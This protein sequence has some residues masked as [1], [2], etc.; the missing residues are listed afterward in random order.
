MGVLRR[1]LLTTLDKSLSPVSTDRLQHFEARLVTGRFNRAHQAVVDQ[2]GDSVQDVKR[3][4]GAHATDLLGRIKGETADEDRQSPEQSPLLRDQEVVAPGDRVAHRP[5]ASGQV[6]P[7]VG[8][9][10]EAC[11]Q[12]GQEG[13]RGE[14]FGASG[15][16]LDSER[17]AVQATTDGGHGGGIVGREGEPGIDGAG[18]EG[19]KTNRIGSG[20][21]VATPAAAVGSARGGTG[22]S[23]SPERCSG[24]RL[25]ANTASWGQL[26]RSSA[27]AGAADNTCSRLSSTSKRRRSRSSPVRVESTGRSPASWTPSSRAMAAGTRSGS[28]TVASGTKTAPS[29]NSIGGLF[30]HAKGKPGLADSAGTEQGDQSLAVSQEQVANRGNLALPPDERAQRARQI[31]RDGT[32]CGNRQGHGRRGLA[33]RCGHRDLEQ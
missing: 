28:V 29:A 9:G 1:H 4:L 16:Q 25:V 10:V 32:P 21:V 18:T 33:Q 27:M 7:S 19:K 3:R 2:G 20:G 5:L 17:Q 8:E 24:A 23:H 12:A 31:G 15:R 6:T 11:L 14:H 22:N 13:R 26:E 30:R